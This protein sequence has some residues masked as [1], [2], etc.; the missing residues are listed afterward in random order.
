M[1]LSPEDAILVTA[2]QGYFELG[3]LAEA[4]AQLDR[5]DA[6]ARNLPEVLVVRLGIYQETKRWTAMQAVAKLLVALDPADPQWV[7]TWAYATRRAESIDLARII[8]VE[9]LDKHPLEPIIHY[10]LACYDCR[11]GDLP[12]AKKF[13]EAAL[14]LSPNIKAMALEDEDL[15]PLW[16]LL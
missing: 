1:P 13:I 9:A 12:A 6:A 8:L 2:A 10:N 4:E 15:K 7:I 16:S 11:L 5:V 14:R 3:M